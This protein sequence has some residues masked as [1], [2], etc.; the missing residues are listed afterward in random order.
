MTAVG[1]RRLPAILLIVA[2]I[3]L[4]LVIALAVAT[5]RES[6]Y[7][8]FHSPDKR[9]AIV[10]KRKTQLFGVGP[11][12]SGDAPGRVLLVDAKGTILR[13]APIEMVQLIEVGTWG[14]RSVE[15]RPFG[16][17]RLPP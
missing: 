8:E 4:P 10:V 12:Q 13:E 1:K 6:T 11:G 2:V 14:T 7:L 9:L 3:G 16:E 15:V 5:T 17:W